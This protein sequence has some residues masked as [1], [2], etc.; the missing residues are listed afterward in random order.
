MENAALNHFSLFF[1]DA[2]DP[3]KM[4]FVENNVIHA[5]Q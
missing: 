2:V 3:I 1:Y 5:Q 4:I